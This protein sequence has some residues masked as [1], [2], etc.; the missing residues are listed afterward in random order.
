M[1]KRFSGWLRC[2]LCKGPLELSI[3][4]ASATGL[5]EEHQALAEQRDVLNDDFAVF[6]ETAVLL[7]PS[8][9]AWFPVVKGLPVLLPYATSAHLQFARE[10][11]AAIPAGYMPPGGRAAG[12]PRPR[13]PARVRHQGRQEEVGVR[14]PAGP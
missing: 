1:W 12:I 5:S 10:V 8:C 11:A 7:C 14:H 9:R 2:P 4:K 3:E 6:V 13:G